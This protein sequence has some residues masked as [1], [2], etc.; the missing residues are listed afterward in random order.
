MLPE[1]Q[2]PESPEHTPA[3]ILFPEKSLDEELSEPIPKDSPGIC[4]N[5]AHENTSDRQFAN[6]ISEA[7]F[8]RKFADILRK[9]KTSSFFS[10]QYM[11]HHD[12]K[13]AFQKPMMIFRNSSSKTPRMTGRTIFEPL[14]SARPEPSQ[15][16]AMLQRA[17]ARPS[18]KTT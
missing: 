8:I 13:A 15:L 2:I 14:L 10:V 7:F 6:R 4:R 3:K 5:T 12:R 17:P 16:P 18:R 11:F 9:R 1:K